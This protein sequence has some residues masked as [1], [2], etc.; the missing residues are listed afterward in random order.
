M[1]R[2]GHYATVRDMATARLVDGRLIGR[3]QA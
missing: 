3:G 1:M 2:D